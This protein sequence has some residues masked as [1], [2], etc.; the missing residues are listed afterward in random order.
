ML[1]PTYAHPSVS[2]A[3]A[4]CVL[5]IRL[6]SAQRLSAASTSPAFANSIIAA[7]NTAAA[8]SGFNN[9]V[10]STPADVMASITVPDTVSIT[11]PPAPCV[12]IRV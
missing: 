7:I 1:W 9:V 12:P 3:L 10:L 8:S 11:L 5:N 2:C 4:W 6:A